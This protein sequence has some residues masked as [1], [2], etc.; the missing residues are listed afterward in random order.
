MAFGNQWL[1]AKGR[2]ENKLTFLVIASSMVLKNKYLIQHRLKIREHFQ[3]ATEI[4][5][6]ILK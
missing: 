2:K 1:V 3:F 4:Y 5:S 6:I